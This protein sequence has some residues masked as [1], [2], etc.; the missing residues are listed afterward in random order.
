MAQSPASQQPISRKEFPGI[1]RI[2]FIL[3]GVCLILPVAAGLGRQTYAD[4]NQ[5]VTF[6]NFHTYS[7]HRIHLTDPLV[8]PRLKDAV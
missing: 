5:A 1:V 3:I 4:V 6:A 2:A 7:W 8:E